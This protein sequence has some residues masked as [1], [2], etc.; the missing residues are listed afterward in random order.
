HF[1]AERGGDHFA[2]AALH[3]DGALDVDDDRRHFRELCGTYVRS[4][5]GGKDE[6]RDERAQVHRL[7]LTG[8]AAEGCDQCYATHSVLPSQAQGDDLAVVG[9]EVVGVLG[10]RLERFVLRVGVARSYGEVL[11]RVVAN[12]T[13]AFD[14]PLVAGEGLE[15][16]V[17]IEGADR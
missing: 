13:A 7:T 2:V 12:R 14:A 5:G 8:Q 16:V 6:E 17:R 9:I 15:L 10:A 3:F 4:D 11:E 1:G